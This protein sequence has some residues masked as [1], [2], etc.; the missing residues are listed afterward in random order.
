MP[1]IS[2]AHSQYW[3]TQAGGG[4]AAGASGDGGYITWQANII[5]SWLLVGAFL[6][7]R[8]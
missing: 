6:L 4:P 7:L 8:N 1:V 5:G 3:A 2:W